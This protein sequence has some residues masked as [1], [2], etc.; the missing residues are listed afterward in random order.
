MGGLFDLKEKKEEIQNLEKQINEPGFW[1]DINKANEVNKNFRG[2]CE[3][4]ERLVEQS[5]S[6][7]R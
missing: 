2:V 7:L 4:I 6:Q 1:N 5:L 3:Y